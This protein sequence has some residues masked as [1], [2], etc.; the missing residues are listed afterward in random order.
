MKEILAV[1][2]KQDVIQC[3]QS[4]DGHL[5]CEL[6]NADL[7]SFKGIFSV[8]RDKDGDTGNQDIV[9]YTLDE[10]QL[11]LKGARLANTEWIV[12]ICIYSGDE[13]KIMMNSQKGRVKMSHLEGFMNKL[14]IYIIMFQISLCAIIAGLGW[15]QME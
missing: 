13:T 15:Y 9:D 3:V 2:E 8:V 7:H 12:G 5:R 6:P 4:L 14:V 11:L 1:N 10:K